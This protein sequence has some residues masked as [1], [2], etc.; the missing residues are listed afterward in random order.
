[1]VTP[2]TLNNIYQRFY[3][4]FLLNI[5]LLGVPLQQLDEIFLTKGDV[6]SYCTENKWSSECFIILD[7]DYLTVF[8]ENYRP[9]GSGV[10]IIGI[11]FD[12]LDMYSSYPYMELCFIDYTKYFQARDQIIG[13]IKAKIYPFENL[14]YNIIDKYIYIQPVI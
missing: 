8:P 3:D 4:A 14:D 9:A 12:A 1:M 7:N 13:N 5:E 11:N 2:E 10:E 6:L